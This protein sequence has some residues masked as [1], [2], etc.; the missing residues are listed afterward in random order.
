MKAILHFENHEAVAK[1]FRFTHLEPRL[2]ETGLLSQTRIEFQNYANQDAPAA[3]V[4]TPAQVAAQAFGK[5]DTLK[6]IPEKMI[7]VLD[8]SATNSATPDSSYGLCVLVALVN[9]FGGSIED[10]LNKDSFLTVISTL[11]PANLR[12][13]DGIIRLVRPSCDLSALHSLWP[14]VKKIRNENPSRVTPQE[15]ERALVAVNQQGPR[16]ILANG[17]NDD[18]WLAELMVNW[19]K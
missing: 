16:I 6:P 3:A 5:W 8:L 15:I 9:K 7:W 17:K 1:G 12:E 14:R 2:N 13:D 11:F 19:L 4:F 18:A 10:F